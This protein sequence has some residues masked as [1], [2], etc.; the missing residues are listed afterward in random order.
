MA[1]LNPERLDQLAKNLD[2]LKLQINEA[3]AAANRNSAEIKLIAVT[4]GF[5]VSDMLA[6]HQLGVTDFGESN[7]EYVR[8][9]YDL[10]KIKEDRFAIYSK[11]IE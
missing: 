1:N 4:K 10:F 9:H 11:L 7:A 8:E 2:L 3:A 6:L 5:P